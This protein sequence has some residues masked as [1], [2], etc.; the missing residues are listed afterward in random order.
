MKASVSMC[1]KTL[2]PRMLT[3]TAIKSTAQY[4]KVPCHREGSYASTFKT[5]RP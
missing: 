2:I 4:N 1:G 3:A 5:I